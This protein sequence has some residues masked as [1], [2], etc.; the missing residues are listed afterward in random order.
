[1][2]TEAVAERKPEKIHACFCSP[3]SFNISIYLHLSILL[4]VNKTIASRLACWLRVLQC[5]FSGNRLKPHTSPNIFQAFYSLL[6]WHSFGAA[7]VAFI[8]VTNRLHLLKAYLWESL[9]LHPPVI[10]TRGADSN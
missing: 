7:L 5:Y 3:Q 2:C 8:N 10:L 9:S 1:M 6:W 4:T